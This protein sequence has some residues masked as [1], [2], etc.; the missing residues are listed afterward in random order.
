ME[1]DSLY[2]LKIEN[3]RLN[4]KKIIFKKKRNKNAIKS[5]RILY[6]SKCLDCGEGGVVSID[7]MR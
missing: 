1:I 5:L 3:D 7:G 4:S 6:F 2:E